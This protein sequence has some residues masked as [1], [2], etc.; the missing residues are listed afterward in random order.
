MGGEIDLRADEELGKMIYR[1]LYEHEGGKWDA[2]E[3]RYVW[4]NAGAR[5]RKMLN[6]STRRSPDPELVEARQMLAIAC[7][8]IAQPE[9]RQFLAHTADEARSLLSRIREGGEA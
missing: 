2:V 3:T 1:A 7:R 9:P 4:Y 6:A 5:L 8:I